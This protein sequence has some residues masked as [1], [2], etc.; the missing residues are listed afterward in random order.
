MKISRIATVV[1]MALSTMVA[2]SSAFALDLKAAR[3]QGIVGEKLDG[4]VAVIKPSP[5]AEQLVQDVNARR[6]QEYE[7]ISK[8]NGK[9]TDIVA[10]LAMPQVV[11]KLS[12]GSLYQGSDGSWKKR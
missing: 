3:A 9:P 5:E 10:K 1:C 6:L 11:E 7:R 4:Y 2:V 8:E 12:P